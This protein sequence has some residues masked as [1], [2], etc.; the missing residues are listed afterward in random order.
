MKTKML[1]LLGLLC[2]ALLGGAYGEAQR[3]LV[4]IGMGNDE[5]GVALS[6]EEDSYSEEAKALMLSVMDVFRTVCLAYGMEEKSSGEFSV[7]FKKT[8]A[9][10]DEPSPYTLPEPVQ[11]VKGKTVW[12]AFYSISIFPSSYIERVEKEVSDAFM[13]V[14]G[15]INIEQAMQEV[16]EQWE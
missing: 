15:K 11:R 12:I 5:I 1:L 6:E 13:Q 9:S 2:L 10:L 8:Y 3:L 16:L 14:F 7:A 4:G